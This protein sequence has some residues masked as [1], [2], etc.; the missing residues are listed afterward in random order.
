MATRG[1]TPE[2]EDAFAGAV[3]LFEHGA[4][5][6]QQFSVLRGLAS[7]YQFRAQFDQAAHLGREILALGERENDPRMLIDG[8]LVVGSIAIG[9][10]SVPWSLLGPG[11]P[12]VGSGR[13][14]VFRAF[15]DA[16][17][18]GEAV[19]GGP[20]PVQAPVPPTAS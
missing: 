11:R 16:Q 1:F 7:L 2:V 12:S 17:G 6:R 20:V 9:A 13:G 15:S 19:T 14:L 10:D 8:H 5:V 18:P 4:D 3:A